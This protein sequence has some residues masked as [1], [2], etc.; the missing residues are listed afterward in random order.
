[1]KPIFTQ[2]DRLK[3]WPGGFNPSPDNSHPGWHRS[4]LWENH[5]CGNP[6]HDSFVD[7]FSSQSTRATKMCI[8]YTI[9]LLCSACCLVIN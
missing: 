2:K 8:V 3:T 7:V 9:L 5:Y 1:L 6:K 4:S